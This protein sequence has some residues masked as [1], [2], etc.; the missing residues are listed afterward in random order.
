MAKVQILGLGLTPSA[1]YEHGHPLNLSNNG[2][3]VDIGYVFVVARSSILLHHPY[4]IS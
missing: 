2:G 1:K 3:L 4:T